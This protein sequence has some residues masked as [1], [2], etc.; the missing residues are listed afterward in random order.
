MGFVILCY[1]LDIIRSGSDSVRAC[2]RRLHAV[3]APTDETRSCR[4]GAQYFLMRFTRSF[5]LGHLYQPNTLRFCRYILEPT[6]PRKAL[7]WY[8][9]KVR[10]L[11]GHQAI[12]Y[13][14]REIHSFKDYANPPPSLHRREDV[15]V[16]WGHRENCYRM[17]C[18]T[19]RL[20]P[21]TVTYHFGSHAASIF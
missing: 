12:Q 3:G 20:Y 5:F 21:Y 11:T 10:R 9:P 18:S 19:G 13:H 15:L 8:S 14:P 7:K 17:R 1:S 16:G 2:L 6:L 4:E